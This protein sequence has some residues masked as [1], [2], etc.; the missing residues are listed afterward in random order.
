MN[1]NPADFSL[2][3]AK[4]L[5][6]RAVPIYIIDLLEQCGSVARSAGADRLF[7]DKSAKQRLKGVLGAGSN[8]KRIERWLGVYAVLGDNG[9]YITVAHQT[10][11]RRH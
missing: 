7:F 5:Q 6:Q 2:H 10:R 3:A 4:R 8:M 11:R 1:V 9:R